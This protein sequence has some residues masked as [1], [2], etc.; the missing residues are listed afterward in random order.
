VTSFKTWKYDEK[1]DKNDINQK[2]KDQYVA[3]PE[4][5]Y[6]G[7]AGKTLARPVLFVHGLNSDFKV[8]GVKSVVPT[9][10]ELKKGHP[11]FQKGLVKSYEKGSAP[12]VLSRTY[13]ID[14]SD[15]GIN[16]NG[17]Y[18]YQAPGE[19]VNGEWVE[20]RPFWSLND[21]QKSQSR[22]LYDRIAE[23]L[24]DFYGSKGID[25]TSVENTSIDLVG[26][27]QGGLVIREMFRG[28]GVDK[29]EFSSGDSNAANHVRKIITVDTPHFGS[30][31]ATENA[32]DISE[33]L[34]GLK[35][36]VEDLEASKGDEPVEH[37]LVDAELDMGWLDYARTVKNK[38]FKDFMENADH[39]V[40]KNWRWVQDGERLLGGIK[41]LVSYP[42]ESICLRVK[43]PYIGRYKVEVSAEGLKDVPVMEMELD[44]LEPYADDAYYSRNN[45]IHLDPGGSFITVLNGD[46]GSA[47]PIKPN[48]KRV[49]MLPL[50]SPKSTQV[51]SELLGSLV[52][53]ANKLCEDV[54]NAEE[55]CFVVGPFFENI[56]TNI[57]REKGYEVTGAALKSINSEL[58]KALVNIQDSWFGKGDALVT[59]T[60]QKFVDNSKGLS[61]DKISE[62]AEPRRFVF[63]DA[64]A[65]W[66]DVLHGPFDIDENN[67]HFEGASLQGLDIVCALDDRCDE[68]AHKDASKV[69]YLN[70]GSVDFEGNFDVAPIFMNQGLQGVSISDGENYVRAVYVPGTGSVVYYTDG[71]GSE[72]QDVLF[73][74]SVAT[75]PSISRLGNVLHVVFTNQSGKSFEKDYSLPN[76]SQVAKFSVLVEDGETAPQIIMGSGNVADLSSQI[77]PS[78]PQGN[79]KAKSDVIVLHR[80]AREKN[81]K[82]ISRPRI[83]IANASKKDINGFKIAYYF[84]ADPARKPIVEVDYPKIP[85]VLE[86]LGGDQWR[87]ILDAGDQ[88]LEAGDILPNIEG[89]Q[90]R[91][92]YGDWADY[93][94]LN[95]WSADHNYGMPTQNYKIVVYD[96]N[97]NIIW[98]KEPLAFKSVAS[99]AAAKAVATMSWL[100]SAPYEENT[101]KP[102]VIVKNVGLVAL[103]NYKAKLWFRVPEGKEL[104]VPIGDW[105]TPVSTPTLSNIGDNVW[106]LSLNFDKYILY[107]GQS[108]TEGNVGVHLKDWSMFDKT[109]CG[110]ALFDENDDVIFGSVPTVDF[111]KS[112]NGPSFLTPFYAWNF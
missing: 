48:G 52:E 91:I 24:T 81:E 82:N 4:W 71:N 93:K 51:L 68:I 43:G 6:T 101:L 89:W 16:S 45:G 33:D 41:G 58:W 61:P 63:H 29:R 7:E 92:H 21:A 18:F 15:S 98:G 106:E 11:D 54:D 100:D 32:D 8:W 75:T 85:V 38:E 17:I 23:V 72:H 46:L 78:V 28:L 107:A 60:S 30:E 39:H 80:E 70:L 90:I 79:I 40:W 25:W 27:S 1:F 84:T 69:L 77:P 55:G 66:E 112:F 14:V 50:Y 64:L 86:N 57:A 47:Y 13:N 56:V 20:A 2:W 111:C 109:I 19:I 49:P 26:H 83:L 76:L 59:E 5:T 34:S 110:I 103:R 10:T 22:K 67:L 12:D 104:Y 87:F 35:L 88:V 65:P 37:L 42:F 9:N 95:D 73:N 108:V 3:F 97:D 44:Q 62:F 94:Y 74:E 53:G 36:I 105:Y 99:G 31:L 102:Q 96:M